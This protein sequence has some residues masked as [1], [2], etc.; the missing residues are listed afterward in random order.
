MAVGLP[1]ELCPASQLTNL[2]DGLAHSRPEPPPGEPAARLSRLEA[3][4]EVNQQLSA[5]QPLE[6]VLSMV[7]DACGQ[8]LDSDS[9]GIRLVEG[10]DLVV[11]S[12]RGDAAEAMKTPRLK[13]GESLSGIVAATGQ[14]LL[15]DDPAEDPRLLPAHR[16][17]YRRLGARAFLGVPVCVDGRTL[18]VLSTRTKR[19]G[20]FSGEDLAT[21]VAFASQ[22]AIA[23]QNARL[24]QEMRRANDELSRTQEQLIQAKE[25]VETVLNSMSDAITIIDVQDLRILGMNNVFLK[26][27]GRSEHDTLGR[28]CYEVTHHRQDP[29]APPHDT[30]PLLETV[31][32]GQHA[33]AEHVHRNAKGD[34]V[35]V[36]VSTS[37]IRDETGRV[38][39][40]VHVARDIS[41]RKRAEL[42]LAQKAA[43]L[44][45]SNG[46]LQEFA[47]IASH[48]L[49]EPLRKVMA[50][51]DRLK[52]KCADAL[53]DQGRDYLGR[54]QQA[55]ARMQ[56]LI[57]D[58]LAF[59][60]VT[61]KGHALAPVDLSRIA[62]EVMSDL[63]VRIQNTG[64]RLEVAPLPT[65]EADPLQMRQLLQNLI[66]NALKFR[67]AEDPPVIRVSSQML[68]GA[69][70]DAGHDAAAPLCQ[71]AVKDNGIGFEEQ[72]ASRIFGVFQR[73]H[74]R[75][76]YEGTG[77]GLAIC[78]RI[79]ERHGGTI[80]AQ[81]APGQGATFL[82][83]LPV[84]QPKETYDA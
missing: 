9:V 77:I 32:S 52:S 48:D 41:E 13:I 73:L 27:L 72:H 47:Y 74:G 7:A 80:T 46:E 15:V 14:P 58:L 25:F 37:P 10:D 28:P 81:S 43:Q 39:K 66:G 79:A 16:D 55:T 38:T 45:R 51:G 22:A 57:A 35:Y 21:A 1:K 19:E 17:A 20:G 42:A 18:G 62:A 6:S 84:H 31:K 69:G 29:C 82:V 56:G 24:Y 83:T 40:V 44:S 59:S 12:V 36:E 49:Q 75:G 71:L 53:T 78:R 64:A 5:I 63:E 23:I 33:A 68:G 67:R 50:F 60:R 3:L 54:M 61:S 34:K 26:S 30:C 4:L 76:E 2:E 70:P 11:V 65:I 8:L